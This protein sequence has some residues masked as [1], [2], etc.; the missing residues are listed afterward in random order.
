MPLHAYRQ[1]DTHIERRS[2]N[3]D[4]A[5]RRNQQ[6]SQQK[7]F[8]HDTSSFGLQWD[9]TT[10]PGRRHLSQDLLIIRPGALGDTLLLAPVLR[11]LQNPGHVVFAGTMPQARLLETWNAVH[12]AVDYEAFNLYRPPHEVAAARKALLFLSPDKSLADAFRSA[13]AEDVFFLRPLPDAGEGHVVEHAVRELEMC[14]LVSR[15]DRAPFPP[16]EGRPASNFPRG[17]VVLHAGS[18]SGKKNWP[19]ERFVAVAEHLQN[20][21]GPVFWLAGPV[22]AETRLNQSLPPGANVLSGLDL[23]DLAVMLARAA[24]VLGNDSGPVHLAALLGVPAVAIF[25]NSEPATWASW[26]RKTATVGGAGA[27]PDAG[28]VLNAVARLLE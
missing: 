14:G 12:A 2:R 25:Q 16:P 8:S 23:P 26:G 3:P 9:Y 10:K 19:L 5:A 24:L 13:G 11:G 15:P 18:G 21:V 27:P 6:H 4:I 22:E 1:V 20:R 28:E 7:Q 17:G